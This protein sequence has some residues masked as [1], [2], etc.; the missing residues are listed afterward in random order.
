MLILPPFQQMGL[1][2]NMLKTISAQY[3]M[4]DVLEITMED[5]SPQCQRVRDFIDASAC[6]NLSEFSA[7]RLEKGFD[8]SMY[9]AARESSKINRKQARRIY[10]ILRYR[11][12]PK[13]TYINKTGP[14][15]YVH[16]IVA[17][18]T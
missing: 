3:Q 13:V 12:T 18:N 6:V 8:L 14:L 5:P 10:E 7:D 16:C 11:S 2:A 17:R 9:S 4:K 1:A 15:Y